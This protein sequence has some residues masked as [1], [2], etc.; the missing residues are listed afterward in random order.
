MVSYRQLIDISNATILALYKALNNFGVNFDIVWNELAFTFRGL[1][2][3]SDL[4]F[5]GSTVE[6]IAKNFAEKMKEIGLCQKVDI[7]EADDNHV[8]IVI[9]DCVFS[10]ACR[11]L[12]GEDYS[13]QPPCPMIA[14]MYSNINEALGK[15]GSIT[16]FKP[17]HEENSDFFKISLEG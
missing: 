13:A 11:Q 3:D 1:L 2:K 14:I 15:E 10:S 9:G 7:K 5:G 17:I 4:I 16:E 8:S 6:E 12:R